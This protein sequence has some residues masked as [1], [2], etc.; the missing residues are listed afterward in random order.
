MTPTSTVLNSLGVDKAA[1]SELMT[2]GLPSKSSYLILALFHLSLLVS[3]STDIYLL[4]T[5]SLS[6][7][8]TG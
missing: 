8:E 1:A 5:Q 7:E 4:V 3:S 6:P 2:F